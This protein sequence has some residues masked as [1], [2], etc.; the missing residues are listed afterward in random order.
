MMEAVRWG[1]A[2]FT[3]KE[4]ECAGAPRNNFLFPPPRTPRTPHNGALTPPRTPNPRYDEFI[5]FPHYAKHIQ[6]LNAP[7]GAAPAPHA[8]ALPLNP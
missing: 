1:S 6:P 3:Q 8:G 4:K 2:R 7:G 5:F